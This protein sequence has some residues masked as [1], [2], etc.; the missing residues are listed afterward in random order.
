MLQEP[1][2]DI[3]DER[4]GYHRVMVSALHGKLHATQCEVH[5]PVKI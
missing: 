2:I 3:T 1:V 5:Q 4:H